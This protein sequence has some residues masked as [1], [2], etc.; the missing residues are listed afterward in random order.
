MLEVTQKNPVEREVWVNSWGCLHLCVVVDDI[1]AVH[2]RMSRQGAVFV[3][4]PALVELGANKGARAIFTK[5]S[6]VILLELYQYK[7]TN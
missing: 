3:G 5:L 4:P 7:K 2:E 1:F 6:D